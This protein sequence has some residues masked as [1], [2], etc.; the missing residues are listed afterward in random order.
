LK[1]LLDVD[2]WEPVLTRG[3]VEVCTDM[4]PTVRWSPLS[5]AIVVDFGCRRGR[6]GSGAVDTAVEVGRLM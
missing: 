2:N 1:A 3:P 6:V 4:V 5:S